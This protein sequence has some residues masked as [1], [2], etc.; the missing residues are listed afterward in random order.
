MPSPAI[1]CIIN[2]IIGATA[3]RASD[4]GSNIQQFIH[5]K[6]QQQQ[7]SPLASIPPVYSAD[8]VSAM[9]LPPS[10]MPPS[11]PSTA[12]VSPDD[13]DEDDEDDEAIRR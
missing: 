10:Y 7:R 11:I 8:P 6:E 12:A 3:R 9:Q 4:G 1:C 13:E 5:W 2:V